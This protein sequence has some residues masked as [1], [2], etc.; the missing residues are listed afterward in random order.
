MQ[1]IVLRDIVEDT[2]HG[3]ERYY[4]ILMGVVSIPGEELPI[5]L[6]QR[7]FALKL[8]LYYYLFVIDILFKT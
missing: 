2:F 6:Q 5:I 1:G 7:V 3:G 8:S 4:L